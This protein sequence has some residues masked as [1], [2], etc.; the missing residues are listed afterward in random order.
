MNVER[1]PE[2][3]VDSFKDFPFRLDQKTAAITGA[4][5]G[6]GRAIA[7]V[8]AAA[9]ARVRILDVRANE[10]EEVAQAIR[11]KD[12][13]ATAVECDVT[14]TN[15]VNR[16]F[17]HL[18]HREHLDILVNNAGIAHVGNLEQTSEADFE[19]IFQVN[20]AGMYRCMRA[21]VP[22]MA[23]SGGGVILNLASIAATSGIPDRFAYSMSKGAVVA[24]TY[25]VARDYIRP[26]HPLQLYLARP[27]AHAVC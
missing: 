8:F 15:S 21:C 20:V 18:T 22:A 4:A 14:H 25:S 17:E 2:V 23:R 5:S 13:E 10:A 24:M 1:N 9:G 26:E 7:E 3:L 16:A 6:I 11:K 19:R 27:G 12:L